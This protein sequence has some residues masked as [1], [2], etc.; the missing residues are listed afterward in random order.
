ME[1]FGRSKAREAAK[2]A[3]I[4]YLGAIPID[5]DIARLA[6]EGKIEDYSNPLFED[7]TRAIRVNATRLLEPI[8]GAMPIAWSE[9]KAG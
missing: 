2:K 4:P 6:D 8:P 5:P 9:Q 3:G 1:V 7:V